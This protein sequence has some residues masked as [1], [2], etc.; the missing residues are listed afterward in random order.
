MQNITA[1]FSLL[2]DDEP[3]E[4]LSFPHSPSSRAQNDL[5]MTSTEFSPIGDFFPHVEDFTHCLVAESVLMNSD[6]CDEILSPAPFKEESVFLPPLLCT[7]ELEDDQSNNLPVELGNTAR[8]FSY[9]QNSP[10]SFMKKH[11]SNQPCCLLVQQCHH[12]HHLWIVRRRRGRS[13]IPTNPLFVAVKVVYVA[14][15]CVNDFIVR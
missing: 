2:N 13:L 14:K 6:R 9:I 12:H 3:L 1:P 15:T 5:W 8:W 7:N 11:P 4:S 10:P